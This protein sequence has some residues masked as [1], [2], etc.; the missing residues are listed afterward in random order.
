MLAGAV[1]DLG[2]TLRSVKKKKEKDQGSMTDCFISVST[3]M[4][5][6]AL[7]AHRPATIKMLPLTK[8]CHACCTHSVCVHNDHRCFWSQG[9]RL[10]N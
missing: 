10:F 1:L 3:L 9:A 6:V 8:Y 7:Q 2:P 4:P 5:D